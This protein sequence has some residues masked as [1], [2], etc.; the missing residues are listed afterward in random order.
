MALRE[1]VKPVQFIPE[2]KTI[3]SLLRTFRSQHKQM[4]IVI[5]EYGGTAGLVT[6]EDILEEIVGEIEDEHDRS[7][8]P[9]KK[10]A[11][12]K[13]YLTGNLGIREW[14]DYF[15][16][17][18]ESPDFDTVGGLIISLLDNMPKKGDVVEY[19]NMRF[20]VDTL[21]KHRIIGIVMTIKAEI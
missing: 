4:A 19:G 16:V 17:E 3:E 14:C 11:E 7:E 5:D 6:L 8:K 20:T 2:T 15:E 12:G 18:L 10:I 9:I 21:R 1:F 13:Y